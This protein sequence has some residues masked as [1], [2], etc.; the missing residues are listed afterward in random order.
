MHLRR[1]GSVIWLAVLVAASGFG[2][3][4]TFPNTKIVGP[5]G[6]KVDVGT[7]NVGINAGAGGAVNVTSGD[8]YVPLT[9][10]FS[11]AVSPTLAG[12]GQFALAYDGTNLKYSANGGAYAAFGGG[13]LTLTGGTSGDVITASGA[14][15][16]QDSGTALSSLALNSAVVHLTGNETVG[17]TK[18]FS[19]SL[20]VG[21]G[22]TN[23]YSVF[24]ASQTVHAPTSLDLLYS[25][26]NTTATS[27]VARAA[28]LVSQ[29]DGTSNSTARVSGLTGLGGTGSG[30]TGNLTS[31]APSGGAGLVGIL[32]RARHAGSGL[33]T[34]A[35]G[36]AGQ[37][38]GGGNITDA[39][40]F[41]A[42]IPSS[43]GTNSSFAS[44]WA[45]GDGDTTITTRY[46]LRID[47]MSAASTKWGVWVQTDPSFFGG[48]VTANTNL[49]VGAGSAITSSGA[50]GTVATLAGTEALTNKT[51]N[52]TTPTTAGLGILG[53]TNPSAISFVKIAAD[54]SVSTRIPAQVLSDILAAP[55]ASPT[56]TGTV[57]L[58]IVT[59]TGAFTNSFSGTAS[60]PALLV[61]GVPFAGTGTTGFPLVYINDANAT[62]STTLNTAGTYLG[63]N[64]DGT[65]D[66]MNLLKDGTSVFVVKSNGN[67]GVGMSPSVSFDVN[68][69]IRSSSLF[70]IA[71][72]GRIS[73]GAADGILVLQDDATNLFF[74]RLDFGGTS[75][76]YGAIG[77]DSVNGFT[78]QSAA[79]TAT[80][81]DRTT[82]N[83]GTVA[84]RY[85]FG[86]AAPTLTATGTS[87]TDTVASTVYIG[88]APT[89]STNTTIGTTYALNVAAGDSAF[90]G[91]IIATT[92]GKG[93]QVKGGTNAKI[94]SGTLTAG[95]VTITTTAV[96]ANSR[97]FVTDTSTGS[98]VNVGSL[99]VS[100]KTAG[101]GFVVTSTNALD[102][103]T[104]DWMIV[105]QN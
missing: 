1:I 48:A 90:G 43:I 101:S 85:L 78:L 100:T 65:Q 41:L 55:L 8:V 16:I 63:V 82:A 84:N 69:G 98:L 75:N 29:F 59:N 40:D 79:G 93:L 102:A 50:G 97:I 61:S 36:V 53:V 95:T 22:G 77:S 83:S 5:N 74:T 64:G 99:V 70:A 28:L 87:V 20:N 45:L 52:G 44:F 34:R 32:G 92:V 94:G 91:N 24:G 67:V 7:G 11:T 3:L 57:T 31:V 23:P 89:A 42:C 35:A 25:G 38:D 13:G 9:L 27:G 60:T 14:T 88:G 81:N 47:T 58:P 73:S 15:T 12:S 33:V 68:G 103:S 30:S 39:A 71:S 51:Y 54:N 2:Q 105:E 18:T 66:L 46:G 72:K 56:F 10:N 62:A 17:G 76:S 6:A 21:T 26:L 4:A 19:N 80:W 86:I 37:I 104:F 96:T 49:V